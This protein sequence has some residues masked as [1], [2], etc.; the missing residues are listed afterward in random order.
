MSGTLT[1]NLRAINNTQARN[2]HRHGLYAYFY[3]IS[4]HWN[5][6]ATTTSTDTHPSAHIQF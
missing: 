2:D 6:K 4:I 1:T 3:I 5:S